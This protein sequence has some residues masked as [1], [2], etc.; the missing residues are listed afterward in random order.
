MGATEDSKQGLARRWRM[1]VALVVALLTCSWFAAQA[2]AATYT[3]GTTTDTTG[4][5]ANPA[6]GQCSL[7]QLINYE[8]SLKTTPNP[9]DTIIVPAGFYFLTNEVLPISQSVSIVGAHAGNDTGATRIDQGSQTP[10]RVFDIGQTRTVTISGMTIEGGTGTQANN[11]FGG[12][13]RNQGNLT[14][15]GDWITNGQTQNGSGAGVSNDA[16]TLTILRSLISINGASNTNDSGGVQNFGTSSQPGRLTVIDSTI[17]NNTSAQ[18]GGIFSWCFTSTC[19][20]TTTVINSTIAHNDGGN[21][22]ARGGGLLEGAAQGTMTVQNSIVAFNTVDTPSAGTPSNCGG[23]GKITSAGYNI[24]NKSDCGFTSTGDRQNTDPGFTS[25]S[26]ENWG[27]NT[28]TFGLDARSPAVD[29]IPPGSPGCGGT[30]QRNVSTPQGQGCDIGAF[31]LSQPVEGHQAQ[32]QALA[33]PCGVFGQ[34]T[35]NW[36]DGSQPSQSNPQTFVG[37]HTYARAGTYDGSVFYRNDCHSSGTTVSFDIKVQNGINATGA[38]ITVKAGSP[39]SGK[40]A[41]FTDATPGRSPSNF[42]AT[43]N[44]GDGSSSAGTIAGSGSA[45]AVNGSHTYANPATYPTTIA[46]SDVGGASTTANGSATVNTNPSAA[47]G[48][49]SVNSTGAAFSAA[50]NPEG[51]PTTAQW[52]YGLDP[53]ERGPGFSGNVFDQSTAPQTVGSDFSSHPV[54]TTVSNLQPNALYHVRLMATNGAGT[55]FGPDQTFT[56]PKAP[57]PPPPV[58]G[59]TVNVTPNGPVFVLVQGQFVKLTQTLQLPSGTVVDALHGSISL[60]A[61]G[62]GGGLAHD[63]KAKKGK[64]KPKP[65]TGTFGGAVFS[66]GQAKSGPNKG[67]TTLSLVENGINGT[68]SYA[69]CKAK[70]AGDAHAALSRRILQTLRSRSSGRFRTR[71]RYAAGTVRGTAWTTTDRCDGTSI[72]VQV[73]SVLV[74]DLVKHIT[75]LVRAGHHYL[76]K[77]PT[78]KHK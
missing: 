10:D 55:T 11:F 49:P 12:N 45:F 9:P 51:S 20:N 14:L 64:K 25:A 7:R 75:I 53:S 35:I 57:A 27:G 13:I 18:G 65:F 4:T 5:C 8:N 17:A 47:P 67:L 28:E 76:A 44:W 72:A 21:R 42:T 50:I 63:A 73:H 29:A 54:S 30:D 41:S 66:V 22:N 34:A 52:Q 2:H 59:K 6:G 32:I 58:L 68:P 62:F 1:V 60:V 26:L 40:V 71:G 43:I 46:I 24:D 70:R 3:V 61:A 69:S 56:T 23:T 37:T 39:F 74:T 16:G 33:D 77:A 36:G 38:A 15:S 78:K 48:A 31:E 19:P